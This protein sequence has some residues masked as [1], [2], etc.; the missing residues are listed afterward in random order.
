[1][2]RRSFISGIIRAGVTAAILPPAL[3]YAR[4]WKPIGGGLIHVANMG[5]LEQLRQCDRL[6]DISRP[7]DMD[8]FFRT[9]YA[10]SKTRK[11]PRIFEVIAPAHYGPLIEMEASERT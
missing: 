9:M 4:T 10:I 5:V 1:M 2:N 8:E 7:F 3:T 6:I 11:K